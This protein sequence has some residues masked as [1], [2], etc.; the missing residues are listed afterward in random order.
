MLIGWTLRIGPHSE[1]LLVHCRTDALSPTAYRRNNGLGGG[2]KF[3]RESRYGAKCQVSPGD[4]SFRPQSGAELVEGSVFCET[5]LPLIKISG[6]F[7]M[8]V[9]RNIFEC[10]HLPRLYLGHV[11]TRTEPNLS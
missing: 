5:H 2:A 1:F 11:W 9:Q 6:F 10:R 8:D 7:F 4:A 3:K